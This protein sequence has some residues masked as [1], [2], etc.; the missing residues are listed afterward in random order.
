MSARLLAAALAASLLAAPS[1]AQQAPIPVPALRQEDVQPA[2]AQAARD[3][4]GEAPFGLVVMDASRRRLIA[5]ANGRAPLH[6]GELAGLVA[7]AALL[8][9]LGP[10]FRA[11]TRLE[12]VGEVDEAGVLQGDLVLRGGGDP[13][14]GSSRFLPPGASSLDA[15]EPF[16]R[17]VRK[18]GIRR[19][20]GS[21]IGVPGA[22]PRSAPPVGWEG[23]HR[24]TLLH[25]AV[26]G[27]T[28]ADGGPS[29][30]FR[31]ARKFL[32]RT[33]GRTIDPPLESLDLRGKPRPIDP[34]LDARVRWHWD[35]EAGALVVA[36]VLPRGASVATRPILPH[37]DEFA[38]QSL[39]AA[40]V[41]QGVRVGGP[42]LGA[43]DAPEGRLLA[44]VPSPPLQELLAV[45]LSQG[46]PL[47]L[48][49]LARLAADEPTP[50]AAAAW[51]NQ[52]ARALGIAQPGLV[53]VDA[54]GISTLTRV[55]ALS[56]ARAV[57][58]LA[59]QPGGAAVMDRAFGVP[60]STALGNWMAPFGDGARG[61]RDRT[62]LG[63]AVVV[64]MD[65]GRGERLIVAALAS[66]PG[67]G[68]RPV[69]EA[70]LQAVINLV[71]GLPEPPREVPP[72]EPAEEPPSLPPGPAEGAGHPPGNPLT[73][74]EAPGL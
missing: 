69:A 33:I 31:P 16:A 65:A 53:L 2:I 63:S 30:L 40:L 13:S 43:D 45:A 24:G 28:F 36:G 20:E 41:R 3:A 17:A 60:G 42:A 15:L 56:L 38:A 61:L 14:L 59:A 52:Q 71:L 34:D 67:E 62:G 7:A 22:V 1:L 4:A 44:D 5:E 11:S 57:Q 51:L 39:A 48:E 50:E 37:P 19:V 72:E 10:D 49:V 73:H 18:A 25:P 70:A 74:S 64:Q 8:H 26:S 46:E 55:S 23:R 47:Y 29:V 66:R 35:A 27:L 6:P 21:I 58:A 9:Q 68:A 12:V 54:S 32:G